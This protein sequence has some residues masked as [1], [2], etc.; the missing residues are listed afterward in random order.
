MAEAGDEV[1]RDI[2]DKAVCHLIDLAKA[3]LKRGLEVYELHST[4]PIELVA[5]GG[6]FAN[7]DFWRS[8]NQSW[9]KIKLQEYIGKLH[10]Q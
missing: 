1:A 3:V 10:C 6:L 9:A 2:R 4:D 8:F 7:E 5:G